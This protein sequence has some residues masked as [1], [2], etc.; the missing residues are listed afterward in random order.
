MTSERESIDPDLRGP[1]DVAVSD[2]R[3]RWLQILAMA[4]PAFV[5]GAWQFGPG[6]SQAPY[7]PVDDSDTA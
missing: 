6:I 4:G 2:E 7:K 3:P 5:V 1:N